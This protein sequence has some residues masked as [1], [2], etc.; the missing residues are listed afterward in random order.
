MLKMSSAGLHIAYGS[1]S[2]ANLL[3]LL[4]DAHLNHHSRFR[5]MCED[6]PALKALN[7]LQTE[8]SSVVDHSDAKEAEVFRSLLTHLLAPGE[9]ADATPSPTNPHGACGQPGQLPAHTSSKLG[10][11]IS[12]TG[13]QATVDPSEGGDQAANAARFKQR[14]EVFESLLDFISD[15]AKEPHGNLLDIVSQYS[16]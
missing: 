8:V 1:N 10:M 11:S 14:N 7:F 12:A 9:T 4:L 3:L 15:D 16:L 2:M 5:E 6:V 13:L